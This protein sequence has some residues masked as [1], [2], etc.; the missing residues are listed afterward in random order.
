MKITKIGKNVM[1]IIQISIALHCCIQNLHLLHFKINVACICTPKKIVFKC[2]DFSLKMK[3]PLK[4]SI[5]CFLIRLS[6]LILVPIG[7]FHR[8]Q[9]P[10]LYRTHSPHLI[11]HRT[12]SPH[13][14]FYRTQSPHFYAFVGLKVL[15]FIFHRTQSPRSPL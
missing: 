6:P 5:S 4:E 3:S 7:L 12:Q 11:F 13:V 10:R 15:T 8:A 14:I 9:S 2:I 1:N